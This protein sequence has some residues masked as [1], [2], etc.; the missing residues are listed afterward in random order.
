MKSSPATLVYVQASS[1][2]LPLRFRHREGES[3]VCIG[4]CSAACHLEG[5]GRGSEGMLGSGG[6]RE[7]VLFFKGRNA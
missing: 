7:S 3:V 1:C 2:V 5:G 4:C 6:Q